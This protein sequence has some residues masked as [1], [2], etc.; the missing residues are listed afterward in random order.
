MEISFFKLF[1]DNI[2]KEYYTN[3]NFC[4]DLYSS[5]IDVLDLLVENRDPLLKFSI[6]YLKEKIIENITYEFKLDC[7]LLSRFFIKSPVYMSDLIL[8]FKNGTTYEKIDILHEK[9]SIISSEF[10]LSKRDF[11]LLLTRNFEINQNNEVNIDSILKFY[12]KKYIFMIK[13]SDYI[14]ISL[15]KII[16][17]FGIIESKIIQLFEKIDKNNQGIISFEQFEELLTGII[18]TNLNKWNISNY[19]K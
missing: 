10:K 12:A 18:K 5:K 11:V 3:L 7:F 8:K 15:N 16:N 14:D 19:F 9:F 13:I 17:I 1:E 4:F 6:I 2:N